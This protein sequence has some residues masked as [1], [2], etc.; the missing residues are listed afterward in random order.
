MNVV[1]MGTPGFA[2]GALETL[3]NSSHHVAAVVTVPDKPS[4]RGRKYTACD[5]K[6]KAVALNIPVLQPPKLRNPEFLAEI[7]A[8]NADVFA[9]IAFRILPRKLYS[10]PPK[11]SINIHASL[12]PKYRGAAPIQ[13]AIL[14]GETE[15]GLTSFFLTDKVDQGDIIDQ[16]S[17]PIGP[18][19]NYTSLSGRLADAAGSFLVKT[20]ELIDTPG[21]SPKI[22]D[23]SQATPAPKIG[24][25]DCLIDWQHDARR[26]HNQIRA[27]SEH[28]GAFSYLDCHMIK[29]LATAREFPEGTVSLAPGE[30]LPQKKRLFVGTGTTPLQITRIQPEGK[31]A[32]EALSFLNGYRIEPGRTLTSVRKEVI[33]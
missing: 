15:T 5:V 32:M 1:F 28:P 26:V 17:F 20:L 12:L 25:G 10:I 14:N 22:Q 7:S 11:G 23:Q 31:R 8:L 2:C 21:F 6:L 24:P 13:H 3:A 30:L 4:G 9:V 19:E 16:E 18:D 33:K 27:F 29:I